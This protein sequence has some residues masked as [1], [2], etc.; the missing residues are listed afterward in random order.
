M[1]LWVYKG[2]EGEIINRN[3]LPLYKERGYKESPTNKKEDPF[4]TIDKFLEAD[5]E[6]EFI[7]LEELTAK[8]LK[9]KLDDAGIKY[10]AKDT[11]AILIELLNAN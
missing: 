9:E 1:K 5:K 10:K 7:N 3:D 4:V 8:Q 11:K 6:E 2:K